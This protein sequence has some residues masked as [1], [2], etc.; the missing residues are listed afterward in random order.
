MDQWLITLNIL[1]YNDLKNILVINQIRRKLAFEIREDFVDE[2]HEFTNVGDFI[3]KL[4][5]Y[6]AAR[7]NIGKGSEA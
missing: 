2:L 3:N 5:D 1:S 6:D 4:D 7:N